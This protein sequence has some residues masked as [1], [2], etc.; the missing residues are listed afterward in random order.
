[1]G[2]FGC[3]LR[4]WQE[5]CKYLL[6]LED[7]GTT[8]KYWWLLACGNSLRSNNIQQIFSTYA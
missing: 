2:K 3:I 4:E 8:L 7:F 5:I 1:M 6:M